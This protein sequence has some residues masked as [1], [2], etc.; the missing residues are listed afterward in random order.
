MP[1]RPPALRGLLIRYLLIP[2]GVLWLFNA[3]VT[4]YIAIY[5]SNIAYDR[6]LYETTR[7]LAQQM[8]ILNDRALVNL[9]PA[10]WSI[11]YYDEYDQVYTQVRWA[12]GKTIASDSELPPPPARLRTLNKPIFHN[13]VYRGRPVRIASLYFPITVAGATRQVLV[14]AA[15]TLNKRGILEREIVW[16]VVTPQLV[17][18]LLAALS[19][20]VGVRRGL[21]PLQRIREAI[22]NR[23]HRDLAPVA[24]GN[25]PQEVQPLLHSINGLLQRLN[26][27]LEAQQRF[28]ADAAHQL[29]T[30]LAGLIT[31]S[32]YAQRATDPAELQHALGQ[33]KTSAEGAN[34]LLHQL[35]TLAQSEAHSG[36][37]AA[38]EN[39]DLDRLLREKTAEWAP[40]AMSKDIDIGYETQAPAAAV[41]GNAVLLR[42]L[43]A[44]L[45]D[46]AIRYTPRGGRVTV[47]L[48]DPAHPLIVVEDDGPGIPPSERERVFERFHRLPGS[49]GEGSG[50]GLA[51]VRE[52][53]RAHGA[54]ARIA[55]GSGGRGTRVCVQFE[56]LAR[57]LMASAIDGQ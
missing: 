46:N 29:R 19:V 16:G 4:Y 24:E 35:L 48:S 2:L 57:C 9:P 25:A 33:I 54:C 50:L 21:E 8:Q 40:A 27:I 56:R 36:G 51:I 52:I 26:E 15:E 6:S 42:E 49:G 12:D 43:T 44:N 37:P 20:R 13:A 14:E 30:P 39:I 5:F 34:R 1:P 31:H 53:A 38:F 45:L 18:I 22:R 32:E 7:S 55:D 10:A 28:V 17:L 11:L 23:S 41:H 47:R 3:A